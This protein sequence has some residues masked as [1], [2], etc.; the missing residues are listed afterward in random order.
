MLVG[1]VFRVVGKRVAGVD[2]YEV[3]DDHHLERAQYVEL[4]HVGVLGEGNDQK[5]EPPGMFSVVFGA[6]ADGV[7]RLPENILELIDLDDEGDLARKSF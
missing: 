2:F 5:A 3:V 7:N 1:H 4:R 6:T